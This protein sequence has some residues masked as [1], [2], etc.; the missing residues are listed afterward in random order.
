MP[1]YIIERDM[2]GAGSLPAEELCAAA[3]KSGD[4]MAEVG[5]VIHWQQSYVTDDKVFCVWVA[6]SEDAIR[7]HA[8]V[9]GFPV[10][11]IRPVSSVIDAS[12]GGG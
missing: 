1:K 12:T 7:E 11:A 4:A 8:R 3:R 10:T 2:P 5:A 6:E 9:S